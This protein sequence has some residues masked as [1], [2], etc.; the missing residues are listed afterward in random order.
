MSEM[1]LAGTRVTPQVL[2]QHGYQFHHTQ[3]DE[4]LSAILV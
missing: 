2:L 1:I 3:L 4:A